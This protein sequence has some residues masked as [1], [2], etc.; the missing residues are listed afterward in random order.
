VRA[1]NKRSLIA[2]TLSILLVAQL[3]APA[4]ALAAALP[5]NQSDTT[6]V[7]VRKLPPSEA[8]KLRKINRAEL[9]KILKSGRGRVRVVTDKTINNANAQSRKMRAENRDA[10]RRIYQKRPDLLRHLLR[11]P[12]KDELANT[13][14]T[15]RGGARREIVLLGGDALI[16]D[17]LFARRMLES[18]DNQLR[19]Y[20]SLYN[21]IQQRIGEAKRGGAGIFQS[22]QKP[23][24]LKT[25]EQIDQGI[26]RLIDFWRDFIPGRRPPASSGKPLT[27]RQEEG[28]G[29]GGD[30]TNKSG[31][32]TP[33]PD[34]CGDLNP[35]GLR[36]LVSWPLK[37]FNTCVRDQ[38]NRGTC[39]SFAAT[40]AMESAVAVKYNRWVNLSEQDLQKHHKLDWF[41][42]PSDYYGDGYNPPGSLIFQMLSGYKFPF[43]RNWDYNPSYKRTKDDNARVYTRSC[44][45]YNNPNCSNTNHQSKQTCYQADATTFKEVVNEVCTFIEGI[46][47]LGL[48]G[49]WACNTVTEVIE[50]TESVEVC[51]YDT[52]V[53]GTSNFSATAASI[54]FDPFVTTEIGLALA[55]FNLD[56]LTP[57]V[58]SFTTTP[59]FRNTA[60]PSGFVT[61]SNAEVPHE[62]LDGGHAVL[63]TGYVDNANL[64]A[65]VPQGAGGGYLI[66][67]NSWGCEFGDQGYAYLP[68]DWVRKWGTTMVALNG[69][70]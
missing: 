24:A 23:A 68:Y 66:I 58:F 61:F 63:L 28:A 21:K 34:V 22:F 36:A 11:L 14:F 15:T 7:V 46:P 19:T 29:S 44:T 52:S 67:K 38:A 65:G 27:C 70:N 30:Q 16:R 62:E 35:Q 1:G 25:V 4:A 13:T 57:V 5:Q 39:V 49:E 6:I 51:V 53:A 8:G 50:I 54:F 37:A 47:L 55:K 42:L 41:P 40:A 3:L 43:E 10:I 26:A 33:V 48:L 45:D 60:T 56:N 9:E 20:E 18:R 64:P 69:I 31:T 2:Q 32:N 59:N 12:T 17:A